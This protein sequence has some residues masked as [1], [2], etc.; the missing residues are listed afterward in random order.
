MIFVTLGTQDKTFKRLLVKIDELIDKGIIQGEVIVQAG[1]T[2]YQSNHMMLFTF[3]SQEQ[4][5]QYVE[6]CDYMITHAGVGS[7]INGINHQKK[8]IAV[9][10]RAKYGEHENDH[11]VEITTKFA[12]FGYILGCIEVDELEEKISELKDFQTKPYESNNKIFCDLIA[13]LIDEN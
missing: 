6:E 13:R 12:G 10:R 3:C 7:I 5:N 2:S 9:A 8:V 1:K 4:L 11:Q